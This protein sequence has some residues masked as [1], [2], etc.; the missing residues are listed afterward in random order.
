[1][2]GQ[3]GVFAGVTIWRAIAAERH[4]ARLAGAQMHPVGTDLYAFYA[5]A[6][7]WLFH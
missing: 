6:A 2:T 7:I 3:M 5:L 4:P 1:M